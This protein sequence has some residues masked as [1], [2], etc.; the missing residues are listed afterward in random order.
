[1][2]QPSAAPEIHTKTVSFMPGQAINIKNANFKKVEVR[3][4]YPLRVLTGHCHNDYTVQF[5]CE[6]EP[7][8]IFIADTRRPP[9]FMTPKANSVTITLTQF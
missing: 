7:A 9:V 5:F 2:R 1:L 6:G 3:S 8:D 4:E